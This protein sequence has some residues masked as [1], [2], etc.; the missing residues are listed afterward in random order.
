MFYIQPTPLSNY[1]WLA[2]WALPVVI[3]LVGVLMF[4]LGRGNK[5]KERMAN[6]VGA[7]GIIGLLVVGALSVS[8]YVHNY[9]NSASYNKKAKEMALEYNPNQE[10]HLIIQNYKGEQTFEMTGN[11]GFDHE[12]RNVTV[13]D[14]KTGDKTSIYIGE[15][16]LLIIQDKK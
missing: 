5:K 6:L 15:N 11:F 9:K 16:D 3:L 4:L 2:L 13:V 7:L 14:N 10:R 8:S 1:L 12:G